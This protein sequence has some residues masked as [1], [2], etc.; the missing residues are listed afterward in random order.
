[1]LLTFKDFAAGQ[2]YKSGPYVVSKDDIGAFCDV[3]GHS[4]EML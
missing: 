1:M 3:L 4:S 2:V